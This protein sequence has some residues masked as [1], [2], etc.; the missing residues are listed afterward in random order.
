[1]ADARKDP[2]RLI[3]RP[4]NTVGGS[5]ARQAQAAW[6]S[7]LSGTPKVQPVTIRRAAHLLQTLEQR[8]SLLGGVRQRFQRAQRVSPTVRRLL[9]TGGA[10]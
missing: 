2:M 6:Q 8:N 7:K 4:T 5:V 10:G 1:M 9:G 3:R